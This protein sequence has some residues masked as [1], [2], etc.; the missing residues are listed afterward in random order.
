M[1]AGEDLQPLP[2]YDDEPK[3][4]IGTSLKLNGFKTIRATLMNN[5]DLFA[6]TTIGMPGVSLE[7]ITHRLSVYIEA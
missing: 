5:I 6:W 4:Y 3:T 2:L 7:I 1:E